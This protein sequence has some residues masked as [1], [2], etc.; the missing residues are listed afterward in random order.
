MD[1]SL[2]QSHRMYTTQRGPWYKLETLG[3]DI[4]WMQ[5]INH[6]LINPEV[7][8]SEGSVYSGGGHALVR[9]CG[10]YSMYGWA[11]YHSLTLAFWSPASDSLLVGLQALSFCWSSLFSVAI[12]CTFSSSSSSDSSAMDRHWAHLVHIHI[13]KGLR[14]SDTWSKINLF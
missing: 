14:H 6:L 7:L 10:S 12:A 13:D 11:N 5:R 2:V 3:D 9:L 8:Y 4:V 1:Y